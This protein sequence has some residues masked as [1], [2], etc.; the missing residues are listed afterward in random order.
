MAT[1]N[2]TG[3]R[4]GSNRGRGGQ[5]QR[6]RRGVGDRGKNK[7]NGG[8][9]DRGNRNSYDLGEISVEADAPGNERRDGSDRGRSNRNFS[10]QNQ[11]QTQSYAPQEYTNPVLGVPL[12]E[13][14][15]VQHSEIYTGARLT[16]AGQALDVADKMM[17]GALR[18]F[19]CSYNPRNPQ[20]AKE[21]GVFQS[22]WNKAISIE[23]TKTG[24]ISIFDTAT[25]TT[26]G[27]INEQGAYGVVEQ[28]LLGNMGKLTLGSTFTSYDIV[29]NKLDFNNPISQYSS[30]M[31]GPNTYQSTMTT[32]EWYGTR[33]EVA[34]YSPG[35]QYNVS[36][37]TA[38]SLIGTITWDMHYWNT[39][40]KA[41]EFGWAAEL[42]MDI[43]EFFGVD[44]AIAG[45][46][47]KTA[48]VLSAIFS[49]VYSITNL[50][51]P[52]MQFMAIS[53]WIG[54]TA[55]VSGLY[56]AYQSLQHIA[57][58][59]GW[60][61]ARE[62]NKQIDNLVDK[63]YSSRDTD[64]G[65]V[66]RD[67]LD[68]IVESP[69]GQEI[70]NDRWNTIL[71][72][73]QAGLDRLIP[74]KQPN[75]TQ[76]NKGDKMQANLST[77]LVGM[78]N[79]REASL[80][81]SN[82]AQYL[83]NVSLD[84]GIV[85]SI[86]SPSQEKIQSDNTLVYMYDDDGFVGNI[87]YKEIDKVSIAQLANTTYC[88][89]NG[90]LYILD[91]K[92]NGNDTVWART[93]NITLDQQNLKLEIQISNTISLAKLK[94]VEDTV[95]QMKAIAA[96]EKIHRDKPKDGSIS[97]YKPL[98]ANLD[99]ENWYERI[100]EALQKGA[101]YILVKGSTEAP[102]GSR[103]AIVLGSL[104]DTT[105]C[106]DK[107]WQIEVDLFV[108]FSSIFNRQTI[109]ELSYAATL[110]DEKT[111]RESIPIKA[112]MA[113]S[114]D[115]KV[116]IKLF[117]IPT[118]FKVKLYRRGTSSALYKYITTTSDEFFLDNLAD[119]PGTQYLDFNE[120][121][122]VKDLQGLVEH[123]ATLFAFRGAN[124]Y[125]SRPGKPN[126]WNEL[127]SITINE[128][129]VGLASTPLGLLIFSKSATYL[130]GG[131]DKFNYT[132]ASVSQSIGCSE[133]KSIQNI[134]NAAIWVYNN[135]LMISLG[136]AINNLT[137]TRFYLPEKQKVINSVVVGDIYYLFMT[138]SIV[139]VDFSG[140]QPQITMETASNSSGAN[141]NNELYYYSKDSK[142]LYKAYNAV[143][144][145]TLKYIT[146][147]FTGQSK[148]LIKEFAEVN[149]V[150]KGS[151]EVQVFIDDVVVL[152]QNII[153]DKIDVAKLGIPTELNEGLSIYLS[154][155]G[156]GEI[157]SFR[158]I[159][160]NRNNK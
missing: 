160:D 152:T 79:V 46:V 80:L 3:G 159:F 93:Q 105:V 90:K 11:I 142:M 116:G 65:Q 124:V 155:T 27:G 14:V 85:E 86:Q 135:Y 34:Q 99:N 154:F 94:Q 43:A 50:T 16:P 74:Y 148:D 24:Q 133:Y 127:Q 106:K 17:V 97:E 32:K 77:D 149:V 25:G 71:P 8:S 13:F 54:A 56:E 28:G 12:I 36:Q 60:E 115:T 35:T 47:A 128:T 67:E 138:N 92:K 70:E 23:V 111:G 112:D 150:F 123:K 68:M 63:A 69:I 83:E 2:G 84:R 72:T 129:V 89:A 75:I 95:K 33:T 42:T 117:N 73:Q 108:A 31:I 38:S 121:R 131:T 87:F 153:S 104:T 125:F 22:K 126:V 156:I 130:L 107:R 134:K 101:R 1:G 110:Y 88:L 21:Y 145:Q 59:F 78:N 58:T 158:Y 20:V 122:E 62:I 52:G 57:E 55:I 49:A 132:L 98:A 81:S 7:G 29:D 15:Y 76:T 144:K 19:V 91:T 18:D 66:N 41:V 44:K 82:E 10:N 141:L 137:R 6:D 45:S 53:K 143:T 140:P 100:K 102:D 119:I 64:L 118:G 51:I 39:P 9:R 26:L 4:R 40:G 109:E 37:V 157:H 30:R 136:S 96:A 5:S 120:I 146:G 147:A 103:I 151:F 48:E 139:K 61:A 114:F 113:L